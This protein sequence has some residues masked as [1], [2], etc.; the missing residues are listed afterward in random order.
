MNKR[1]SSSSSSSSLFERLVCNVL[2][3]GPDI[4]KV[5]KRC[6]ECRGTINMNCIT[7]TTTNSNIN[8][9]N[10]N[11]NVNEKVDSNEPMY[12]LTNNTV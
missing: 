1:S 9:N 11:D 7:T 6:V 5:L 8:S 10:E 12:L 3:R 4:Q 2:H